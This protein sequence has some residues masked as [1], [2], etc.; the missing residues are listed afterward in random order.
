MSAVVKPKAQAL[1]PMHVDDVRA[2]VGIE[3]RVYPFPWTEGIFRD[4]I[5]VGYCCW[6]CEQDGAVIG[7]AIMSIGAG[8][9]HILN[10][11]VAPEQQRH[12]V[13]SKMLDHLI[14]LAQQHG[15]GSM[16]LEVRPTNAGAIR[17][18]HAFGFQEVGTRK[19]YYPAVNGRENALILERKF[20]P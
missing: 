11:C 6:V 8:E 14:H 19:D 2:V 16:F 13:G 18:Y 20:K 1:R 7:Y 3:Q 15:A 12:G 10:L 5:H 17:L 4:C 9:A